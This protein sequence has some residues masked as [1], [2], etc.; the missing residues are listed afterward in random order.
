MNVRTTSLLDGCERRDST[1][2]A[3]GISGT[4]LAEDNMGIMRKPLTSGAPHQRLD[5]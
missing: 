5:S 3:P 4:M 1:V 2:P